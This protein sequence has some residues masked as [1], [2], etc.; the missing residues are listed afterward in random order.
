M[1]DIE[2]YDDGD[3]Y[4]ESD[5][6]PIPMFKY[7]SEDELIEDENIKTNNFL[8]EKMDDLECD[9]CYTKKDVIM[10]RVQSS[11][12]DIREFNLCK[13]SWCKVNFFGEIKRFLNENFDDVEQ[14][15]TCRHLKN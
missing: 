14:T 1:S 8:T 6:D 11:L 4:D 7:I 5:Y 15:L 10:I 9:F 2:Y 13:N 3:E 12:G